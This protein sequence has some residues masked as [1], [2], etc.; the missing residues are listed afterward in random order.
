VEDGERASCEGDGDACSFEDVPFH[1]QG[2]MAC[3]DDV[4]THCGFEQTFVFGCADIHPDLTCQALPGGEATCGLATYD[5]P[6]PPTCNGATLNARV[7]GQVMQFDCSAMGF[8]G[9]L[10][11][12]DPTDLW[13]PARCARDADDLARGIERI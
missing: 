3:T 8:A 7:A 4:A 11:C 10:D 6:T 1:P 12:G 2:V 13:C 9:C 5:D